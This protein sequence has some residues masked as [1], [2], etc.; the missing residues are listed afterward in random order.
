[1]EICDRVGTEANGPK[2]CIRAIVRRLNHPLPTVVMQS[3]T[4]S[5]IDI[6]AKH[7]RNN[8]TKYSK[9]NSILFIFNNY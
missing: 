9:I 1:M 6:V 4:V 8:K 2:D 3:L 7:L 5:H